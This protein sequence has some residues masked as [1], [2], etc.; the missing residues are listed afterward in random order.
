M[1]F[2]TGGSYGLGVAR[3]SAGVDAD[4][5]GDAWAR[6]LRSDH[7]DAHAGSRHAPAEGHADAPRDGYRHAGRLRDSCAGEPDAD[8]KVPGL[9]AGNHRSAS[10][11]RHCAPSTSDCRLDIYRGTAA[12]AADKP[13]ADRGAHANPAAS[14]VAL[15]A[16]N[17][18]SDTCLDSIGGGG[19]AAAHGIGSVGTPGRSRAGGRGQLSAAHRSALGVNLPGVR[20]ARGWVPAE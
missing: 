8:R 13:Y 2:C 4:C 5:L 20:R 1:Y 18:C 14:I 17:R 15:K 11:G 10:P 16:G 12:C 19:G 7:P 6:R 3:P 9:T